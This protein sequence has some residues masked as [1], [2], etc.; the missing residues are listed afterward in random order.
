MHGRGATSPVSRIERADCRIRACVTLCDET[1]VDAVVTN[2]TYDGC[3]IECSAS[4]GIGERL[5]LTVWRRGKIEGEVRWC[6]NG[7]IGLLF[8]LD[9]KPAK[10]WRERI[11]PRISSFAEVQLRR[12]GKSYTARVLD[13]STS[14]CKIRFTEKPAVG[15]TVWIKFPGLE[16]LEAEVQWVAEFVGGVR[17]TKSIHPAVLQLL[18]H[19]GI[20]MG[21]KLA[22]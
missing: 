22:A 19:P 10:N 8:V 15:E 9:A 21:G 17:F 3:A 7:M 11:L 18:R 12:A 1:V 6:S 5:K 16:G 14:G 20:G 2:L 13:A 4:A